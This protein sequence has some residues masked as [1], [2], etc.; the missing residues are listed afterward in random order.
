MAKR[1][2]RTPKTVYSYSGDADIFNAILEDFAKTLK[3]V[4]DS[5]S[6]DKKTFSLQVVNFVLWFTF[7][8]YIGGGV[9][10]HFT[11]QWGNIAPTLNLIIVIAVAI[12]LSCFKENKNL[13]W[14]SIFRTDWSYTKIWFVRLFFL[15]LIGYWVKYF[16]AQFSSNLSK[17]KL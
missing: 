4:V 7:L 2:K 8:T 11:K 10:D 1:R 5:F 13:R 15:N 12:G 6:E 3:P 16:Y 9:L 14:E 17:I